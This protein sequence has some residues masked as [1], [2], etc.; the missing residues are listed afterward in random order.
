MEGLS[1]ETIDI[2]YAL[3]PGFISAWV[4]FGL[5]AHQK[6]SPFE[7]VVQALIFTMF[8][9]ALL[10]PTKA[11]ALLIGKLHS[12]GPWDSDVTIFWSVLLALAV[13]LFTAR[14]ANNDTIHKFLR[15][16]K[17]YDDWR[18]RLKKKQFFKIRVFRWLPSWAWTCRTSSPSEWFSTFQ[19]RPVYMILHLKNQRRLQGWAEQ[20][21]DQQDKGQFAIMKP[22]WLLDDGNEAELFKVECILVLAQDVEMIEFLTPESEWEAVAD[23]AADV[24]RLL[25]SL[26]KK[27]EKGDCHGSEISPVTPAPASNAADGG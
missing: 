18:E 11:I 16:W 8:V 19:K 21:P 27:T 2:I 3:L 13:G 23:K 22:K 5:T 9:K 12:F 20:W 6:Q 24:Q 15:T 26:Q 25:V 1:K 7:R 4:F 14:L 10:V 17:W